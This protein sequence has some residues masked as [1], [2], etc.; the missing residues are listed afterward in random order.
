[1]GFA[2]DDAYWILTPAGVCIFFL[3]VVTSVVITIVT[4]QTHVEIVCP[5]ISN[6]TATAI[7][8]ATRTIT[9]TIHSVVN[10]TTTV[11]APATINGCSP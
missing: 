1:M 11:A 10:S 9:V 6:Q 2:S 8:N 3:G 5:H 7:V 4:G